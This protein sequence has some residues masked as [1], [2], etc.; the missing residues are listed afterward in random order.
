V[1]AL[2]PRD[3]IV[4]G[5]LVANRG[6]SVSADQLADALWGD[7]VPAS[8]RK[9]VQG[10]VARLRRSLGSSA[11]ET[12]EAGYRLSLASENVDA[13][14]FVDLVER[15]GELSQLGELD[16]AVYVLDLALASWRGDPLQELERW[17]LAAGEIA[18]LQQ[19]HCSAEE[20]RLESLVELGR[21]D[22]AIAAASALTVSEPLR[23]R[24]WE[25]LALALYRSGRQGE[26]LKALSRARAVLRDQLGVD[27]RPEL[28]ELELAILHQDAALATSAER[29][30]AVSG[31][32]PY[33]GLE[34]Y[35]V[36][37]AAS[38]FGRDADVEACRRRLTAT[39]LLVV[40][41]TSGSGKSSLV[42]AGLVPVLRGG[43]RPVAFC[44]P[45]TDPPAAVATALAVS[46]PDAAL[47]VDQ[48]EEMFTVCDDAAAR[49][50]FVEAVATHAA[51]RQVVLVLRADHVGAAAAYPALGRMV[52]DGLYLLG[53]MSEPQLREAIEGPASEAGLLL[54]PG[55]V[56]LLVRDVVDE[57]GAL[58]LLSHALAETWARREGRVLTVGGYRDAGGVR[59]AVAA[60]AERLYDALSDAERSVARA[61]FLRL[62]EVVDD[63]DPV[64]HRLVRDDVGDGPVQRRVV[65]M[66]LLARLV[67]AGQDSL[68]IAHE[69]LTRA[70]PRL[71]RWL[72]D[73][74]EGQ[75]IRRHL[76][77]AAQGWNA[78]GRDPAELYRGSRLHAAEEW[79]ATHR[80][81]P[82]AAESAFLQA[83]RAAR[84][85][86][87]RSH[88]VTARRLRRHVVGLSLLLVVALL[89]AS[90]AIVEQRRAN[91]HADRADVVAR[92]AQISNLATVARTLPASQ[93][94]LALLLGV[95]AHRLEPTVETE[96]ALQVALAHTPPGLER[97]I[98]LDS[99]TVHPA[100]DPTGRLIAVPRADGAVGV[101]S[102]PSLTE[103]RTLEGRDSPAEV[104]VFSRDGRH[105]VVGGGGGPID[106][107]DVSSGRR[108]GAPV[109]PAGEPQS[110]F[111]VG[112]D[113]ADTSRLATVSATDT[114]GEVVLWDRR[115]V[116]RPQRMGQ[117]LRFELGNRDIPFATTSDDG[118]LLA[119]GGLGGPTT[120]VWDLQTRALLHELQ[121]APGRFVPG[122]H[123]LTTA[124]IDRITLW[125]AR[126][127]AQEGDPLTD[128]G[129]EG[130]PYLLVGGPYEF[131]D[132]GRLLAALDFSGVRVFDLEERRATGALLRLGSR[133]LPISFLPDGR[134]LTGVTQALGVWKLGT[135]D[136]PYATT[137]A[138]H[139]GQTDGQL[140]AGT[141]DALT[142]GLDDHRL[143]RWDLTIGAP[144]GPV[145]AG[146][147][148][149]ISTVS[150]DG[151]YIAAPAIDETA[152][153]IW[154]TTTGERI[155]TVDGGRGDDQ[156]ATWSP[157]GDLLA[158]TAADDKSVRI[159]DV[160]NPV[161]PDLV[162]RLVVE[163]ATV[164]S[165]D[166]SFQG[167]FSPDSRLLAA[168][169]TPQY[170]EGETS[171][172]ST[173]TVF[174]ITTGRTMWSK[175]PVGLVSEAA[176]SPDGTTLAT[177]HG[178]FIVG[179]SF[180]TLWDAADGTARGQLDVPAGGLGVEFVRGGDTLITT[181]R[182]DS[183]DRRA[184]A[185]SSASAQL[186][187]LTTL[188][189][190]G[191][192][193]P[194]DARVG[195]YIRRDAGGTTAIIGTIDGTAVV[196]Y[197]D[198]ERW[199]AL[200][201]AIAGRNLTPAEWQRYLNGRTYRAT[202]PQWPPGTD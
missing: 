109:N 108:S 181:G 110:G 98:H 5:A 22:E 199:E 111:F 94:D 130:D 68:E 75:R 167:F 26:A 45:G 107:W 141:H 114:G 176:F 169:D 66:L 102:W 132:D 38:F 100:V 50:R 99:P 171:R 142:T 84:D 19:L 9:V 20:R 197:L 193:L 156:V 89:T 8:G 65:E 131:S 46:G 148:R 78:A 163:S 186:W 95:E 152:T 15:A 59:G 97:M 70:W 162:T 67:S 87:E 79:A 57:P 88:R 179:E 74:R 122:R 174:D 48:A 187:D 42:R 191:Q 190:I 125:D 198:P 44:V 185:T 25:L 64:R 126:S 183:D 2:S 113:P 157:S 180:V 139:T 18:R 53:P 149:E 36:A 195:L 168:V 118:T 145:L 160:T 27:P 194:L 144:R 116:D 12:T 120:W 1:R 73:D 101:S 58:P 10:A 91:Q 39:G 56:D 134:L 90:L 172:T 112:A 153:G 83:S 14:Q 105:L 137:L 23:E 119:A 6:V 117:P 189:P 29:P 55:L 69:A 135:T 72:D 138:G 103:V 178:D 200:A 24:Q 30:P 123:T 32:C 28:G 21:C 43:G 147:A 37:D 143:L 177:K 40:T 158:T 92:T 188:Q 11:I 140:I 86:E 62:V 85:Q 202:C 71:R 60:T 129:R 133:N 127:G 61:L 150:P 121:G 161:Q 63:G 54:E 128:P 31:R 184:D 81:E 47:V 106:V 33:K 104:A 16:R 196:W 175:R 201:C 155:A 136:P 17:P 96:G 13:W 192:P 164:P 41:G 173:I 77:A 146:E 76:T 165:A 35:D 151:S 7:A 166:G 159:W 51:T 182:T 124:Q 154:D 49:T 93:I 3:R 34:A 115:D 4:L 80:S 82:N 170:I 52:E